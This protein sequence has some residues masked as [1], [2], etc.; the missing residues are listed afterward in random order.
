MLC[1]QCSGHWDAAKEWTTNGLAEEM[2]TMVSSHLIDVDNL[3]SHVHMDQ[4]YFAQRRQSV[5]HW[6]LEAISMAGAERRPALMTKGCCTRS[7]KDSERVFAIKAS[8]GVDRWVVWF[9][10]DD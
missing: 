4:E 9:T 7:W 3:R 6:D 1:G 8:P 2:P 5:E 10:V